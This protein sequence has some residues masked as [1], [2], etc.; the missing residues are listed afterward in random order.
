[1]PLRLA[2]GGLCLRRNDAI[3]LSLSSSSCFPA[4]LLPQPGGRD[5]IDDGKTLDS[6]FST[7]VVLIIGTSCLGKGWT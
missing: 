5:S 7:S 2:G 3:R 1:M 6:N 4:L